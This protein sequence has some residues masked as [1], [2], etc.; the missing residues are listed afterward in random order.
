MLVNTKSARV[1]VNAAPSAESD[2]WLKI[3]LEIALVLALLA[4]AAG[5]RLWGLNDKSLSNDEAMDLRLAYETHFKDTL[6]FFNPYTIHPPL[7]FSTMHVW[8][9]LF[10]MSELAVRSFSVV[11]SLATLALTYVIGRRWLSWSAALVSLILL[12][13]S[14]LL[15]FWSQSIRP[16]AWFT[17]LVTLSMGLAYFAQ[18]KPYQNWRWVIY[19]LSGSSL[20]YAHYMGFHL[21]FCQVVF[22]ALVSYKDRQA[23]LRIGLTVLG[24]GISFLPYFGNFLKHTN[25]RSAVYYSNKGPEQL[26][27]AWQDLG[28]FFITNGLLWICGA[29]FAP[30]FILGLRELWQSKPRL[31][32]WLGLWAML[33]IA[34]SW[35]SSLLQPNFKGYYFACCVPPFL[36]LAAVGLWSLRKQGRFV[37][38]LAL[39]LV[40]SL[41]VVA[42][43]NYRQN[44]Q[45]QEMRGV[46]NY[47]ADNR[48]NNDLIFLANPYGYLFWGFDYYYDYGLKTPGNLDRQWLPDVANRQQVIDLFKNRERVWLVTSY[49]GDPWLDKQIIPNIPSEFKSTFYKY[50]PG[51][52]GDIALSL[53]E[54]K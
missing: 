21:V 40:L 13:S 6:L 10:G 49:D 5:L 29:V 12:S 50:Y 19:G 45:T 42:H 27:E 28:T 1:Y 15:L 25:G 18:E 26:L 33:P 3:G 37:P 23:L 54:K 38:Y 7:Y 39:G 24:I 35:L 4:L 36:L 22:L 46:V 48:Q 20:I 11:M 16:Y 44:Y 51:P 47:I 17:F 2:K 9:H 43:L 34:T 30:L 31:A 14:P 32:L 52:Q 41:S 8:S 53:Y